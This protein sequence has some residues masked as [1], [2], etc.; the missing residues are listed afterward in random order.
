M[1]VIDAMRSDRLALYG[2]T[3][4]RTP[5]MSGDG[6]ARGGAS[7]GRS[8]DLSIREGEGGHDATTNLSR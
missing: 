6:R 1:L 8:S 5:N 7:S 2:E 4:V 3:R